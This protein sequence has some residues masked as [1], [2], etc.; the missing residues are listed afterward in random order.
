MRYI[1]QRMALGTAKEYLHS[2][3]QQQ[4]RLGGGGGVSDWPAADDGQGQQQFSGTLP[5][6][7]L[8]Y[9]CVKPTHPIK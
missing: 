5:L 8:L 3:A 6:P 9:M 4:A 2:K 7:A 1:C